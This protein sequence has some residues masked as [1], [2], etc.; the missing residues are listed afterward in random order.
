MTSVFLRAIRYFAA[1]KSLLFLVCLSIFPALVS[2]QTSGTVR[3]SGTIFVGT[4]SDTSTNAANKP[5]A[6]VEMPDAKMTLVDETGAVASTAQS[7]LDGRFSLEAK[8]GQTYQICWEIQ[9][10]KGCVTRVKVGKTPV[11]AGRLRARL[12]GPIVFGNVLTGDARPCWVQDAFFGLD[13][14]TEVRGGG[15]TTR[16]NTQGEYLLLAPAG[17]TFRVQAGCELSQAGE[18]VTSTGLF[19][20]LD[21][22]LGNRAPRITSVAATNGTKFLTRAQMGETLKMVSGLRE[23]DGDTVEFAWRLTDAQIGTLSGSTTDTE[24]WQLPSVDGSHSVYLMAR[25][26]KGGFAFDRFEMQVGV[27][28]IDVS[29]IAVDDLTGLPVRKA[30]VTLGSTTVQTSDNGWFSLSTKPVADDR[31]VLN[32]EHPNFVLISRILD[33]S[34][35]GNTYR[36]IRTQVTS[37]RGDVDID[38]EDKRSVGICGTQVKGRERGVRRLAP[39]TFYVEEAAADGKTEGRTDIDK[40]RAEQFERE[41]AIRKYLEAQRFCDGR[42]VRIRIP[43]KSLVD[44]T[45]AVWTGMVRASVATLNPALRALPGD[46][47]AIDRN[48]DRVEMLSFGAVYAEFTDTSGRK[49]QLAPGSTAEIMPPVSAYQAASADPNIAQWSYDE[50]TGFWR[51]EA[52]GSLQSTPDGLRYVGKTEHFS[53]INM[54]VAGSDPT[55]ATCVRVEIDSAFSAWNDLTLRAY[56]SYNGDSVQVKEIVLDNSQYHAIYRIPYGTGAPPNTLRLELRGSLSGQQLVLLDNIINTDLRPKMTGTDLWPPYPYT[57]CGDPILLTPAPGVVPAYGDFD[58]TGRPS[59]LIGPYGDFNPADGGQQALDYYA[60]IDPASAKTT[61]GDW[62]DANGFG[63]DGLGAGN[64]TYINQA[65]LN[66]ND[67]GFGRDMH[68][69][70][71]GS[72]LACYVTNY[73]L[74]D[75]IPANADDAENK[76]AATRGATVAMEFDSAALNFENVQFYVF[77]GG[78]AGSGRITFA[79]LD[80]MGPKPVPFLCMVCHGGGPSLTVDDKVAHARFREFDLPSFKYSNNRSW[81]YGQATLDATELGN[82]AA[83]NQMVRDTTVGQPIGLLIDAWYPGG[84]AGDP[85]PVL[86]AAPAGWAANTTEYHEVYG[87]TCRTCHIARDA[88]NPNSF[89]V[90]NSFANLASTSYAVCGSG[91]PK[92][93]FMPNAFV[94]YRNFWV[95][96]LRVQMYED[97]TGVGQNT[98]DD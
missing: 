20:R 28:Q 16:A 21:L 91:V 74:P 88:G 75:Q 1:P 67:L 45:G 98:C 13:V 30:K 47:Q 41:D 35:A 93:R 89:F 14:S 63:P 33:R 2:A 24:E 64:P 58:A 87:Q 12:E 72:N 37:H 7:I 50:A 27:D 84:F 96:T 40:S 83:L 71:T 10:Q 57:E 17:A 26:G 34:S 55:F 59:F 51:E 9:G 42:G 60:A 44:E 86:P 4:F 49:L 36:M 29:G 46:Y 68:C 38:I 3:V 73:G 32:I 6:E 56:V 23:L 97:M 90:F 95:D 22:N 62:W 31:Y 15:K 69:A 76:N 54:D 48:G 61:L 5:I 85:A 92:R 77:G 11:W 70:E 25:D 82:F 52:Q 66:D 39:P 80:G 65:Y 43:A 8:P 81:D 78:V 79:D 94:T 53:T 19:Q 18:V